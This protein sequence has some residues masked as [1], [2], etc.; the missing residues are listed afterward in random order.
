VRPLADYTPPP[1]AGGVEQ[2]NALPHH[3]GPVATCIHKVREHIFGPKCWA[4]HNYNSCGSCRSEFNFVFGSC[5]TFF[6]EACVPDPPPGTFEPQYSQPLFGPGRGPGIPPP[7]VPVPPGPPPHASM[8]L[9]PV[10]AP[11]FPTTGPY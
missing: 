10:A 6:G 7:P 1:H 3:F 8:L 2:P 9:P 5:R 11:T 4:H